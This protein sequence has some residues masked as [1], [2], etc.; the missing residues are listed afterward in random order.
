M[1]EAPPP[2]Y[3]DVVSTDDVVGR[4]VSLRAF[5]V[6]SLD[7]D[8]LTRARV[9]TSGV[10]HDRGWAVVDAA[11]SVVTA[12]R[13]EALRTVRADV[14]DDQPALTLAGAGH[15][16]S[17]AS[18]EAALSHLLGQPVTVQASPGGFNEVAPVH[19]VSRQAIA[20]GADHDD[21]GEQCPCSVQEPRANLLLDLS[22]GELE[23]A[24]IGARLRA[25]DAV[26][27]ISRSPQHCLGVYAD[28]LREGDIATGDQVVLD[29]G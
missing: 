14:R 15:A 21:H 13:A 1:T 11:G 20:R 17:G 24:W 19:L 23:T 6:K 22:G 2:T 4:V 8:P 9:L 7:A 10:Q 12:R 16:L 18:A 25:G 27:R 5:P 26:L 29:R 28:V 3:A